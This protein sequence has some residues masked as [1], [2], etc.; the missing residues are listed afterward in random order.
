MSAFAAADASASIGLVAL[1]GVPVT[2]R[3]MRPATAGRITGA[4]FEPDP[5][6]PVVEDLLGIVTFRRTLQ[7]SGDARAQIGNALLTVDFEAA[8]F[9]SGLPAKGD[10]FTIANEPELAGR[11][12]EIVRVIPDRGMIVCHCTAVRP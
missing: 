4:A 7:D 5:A 2:W 3:P 1:L 11:A 9:T 6:R 8:A 12:A 10:R